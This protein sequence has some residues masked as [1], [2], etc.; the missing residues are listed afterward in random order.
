LVFFLE[1]VGVKNVGNHQ[2]DK[3]H[4]RWLTGPKGYSRSD[5]RLAAVTFHFLPIPIYQSLIGQGIDSSVE[6]L[7]LGAP[8]DF[9]ALQA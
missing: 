2:S 1:F 6:G 7:A 8:Q 4:S 3:C 5:N 9:E